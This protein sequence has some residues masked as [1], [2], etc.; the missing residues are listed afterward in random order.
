ML[1]VVAMLIAVI[2]IL[3]VCL[4]ASRSDHNS[5]Q[6][7]YDDLSTHYSKAI[8]DRDDLRLKVNRQSLTIKAAH[9]VHDLQAKEIDSAY[10]TAK[11]ATKIA[12]EVRENVAPLH[13][14]IEELG[15]DLGMTMKELDSVKHDRDDW[16]AEAIRLKKV[17]E[18]LNANVEELLADS[19]RLEDYREG[20]SALLEYVEMAETPGEEE[21]RG[22]A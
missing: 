13:D 11:A 17:N 16:A 6:Y 5:L 18:T 20:V 19:I 21:E 3:A 4:V 15:A 9:E 7:L 12:R 14:R 22:A 8:D 1:Y 10:E 2:A